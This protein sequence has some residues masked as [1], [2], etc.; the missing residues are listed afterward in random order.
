MKINKFM[1][2]CILPP[3]LHR[4]IECVN[5]LVRKKKKSLLFSSN[6]ITKRRPTV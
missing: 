4:K 1:F 6:H 2:Q 3:F 5:V